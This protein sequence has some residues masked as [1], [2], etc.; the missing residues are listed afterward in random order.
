MHVP[1]PWLLKELDVG[2][3]P[4]LPGVWVDADGHQVI[5]SSTG[6]RNSFCLVRRHAL[7][8]VMAARGVTSL[9]VGIGERGAWPDAKE[10]AGP[11]RRW[12]GV[13]WQNGEDV[14]VDAW[15]EDHRPERPM[16]QEKIRLYQTSS[17]VSTE[18]DW[19]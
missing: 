4:N 6:D 9:W 16:R 17:D 19:R 10:N 13:F 3:D 14:L 2:A 5:V 11:Q 15:A 1:S 18:A 7:E 12:N 8:A